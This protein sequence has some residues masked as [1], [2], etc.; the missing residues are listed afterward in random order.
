MKQ[1]LL[2]LSIAFSIVSMMGYLF[3]NMP[4]TSHAGIISVPAFSAD[5]GVTHLNSMR[6][7]FVDAFNGQVQGSATTGSTTNVLADSIGELDMGNEVNPRVRDSELLGITVDSTTASNAFVDTGL[8]PADTANLTSDISAGVAY[9]NGYRVST[10]AT[11]R[12]YTASVDTYVDLSQTGVFAFSEVAVGAAAP[13]VATNSARLARV[14]TSGTEITSV[15][16]LA[17]RRIPGLIIPTNFRD[18]LYV[19]R[20]SVT[21]MTVATGALEIN[22]TMVSKTTNTT[23][24]LSVAGDWAGGTSLQATNTT[25]FVGIDAS[26]NLRLHTTAPTH[27]NYGVT[28][29]TGRRRYATWSSTVYRIIAWFR[30]N[31]TG[32]GELDAWGVSN[33]PDGG[34]KNAVLQRISVDATTT[35]GTYENMGTGANATAVTFWSSGGRVMAVFNG[36][37]DTV[38]AGTKSQV[39]IQMDGIIDGATEVGG[40]SAHDSH[41]TVFAQSASARQGAFTPQVQW[42]RSLGSDTITQTGA[43]GNPRSLYVEEV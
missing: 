43:V 29:T 18:F 23:L 10:A 35:S 26:G 11:S 33:F 5:S 15:T 1:K 27:S 9:I 40:A 42:R 20:D 3:I 28:N 8:L 37:I 14:T 31:G 2:S 36:A 24:T 13:A 25:G 4:Q 38:G 22:S 34:T 6:T 16:D 21:A 7:T 12:T 19:S 41:V 30:M 39:G 32:S 17:N